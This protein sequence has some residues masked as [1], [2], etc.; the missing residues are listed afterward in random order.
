MTRL[1]TG[2]AV[3]VKQKTRPTSLC[4]SGATNRTSAG[5]ATASANAA[6]GSLRS[7]QAPSVPPGAPSTMVAVPSE[8][9]AEAPWKGSAAHAS[10]TIAAPSEQ[11]SEAGWHQVADEQ[12]KAT[13]WYNPATGESRWDRPLRAIKVMNTF[14]G[15]RQLGGA[16][17]PENWKPIFD[18]LRGRSYWI[19]SATG[20]SQWNK[21]MSVV[22]VLNA[23]S[24]PRCL[25]GDSASVVNGAS[26]VS[27]TAPTR[28]EAPAFLPAPDI[29]SVSRESS[30]AT[31]PHS[32]TETDLILDSEWEEMLDGLNRTYFV[33]RATGQSRWQK[34]M[35]AMR[36][37]GMFM[38]GRGD[39]N[40]WRQQSVYPKLG[41]THVNSATG[42]RVWKRPPGFDKETSA[43][44]PLADVAVWHEMLSKVET[45]GSELQ[46]L[47]ADMKD[48][49]VNGA[50]W[51]ERIDTKSGRT[52]FVNPATGERVWK[53][54]PSSDENDARTGRGIG[55]TPSRRAHE[56]RASQLSGREAG[57]MASPRRA[58]IEQQASTRSPRHSEDD[59]YK[60]HGM[61]DAINVLTQKLDASERATRQALSQQSTLLAQ[62][63]AN[64]AQQ[65]Q[66]FGATESGFQVSSDWAPGLLATLPPSGQDEYSEVAV[67]QDTYEWLSG[68]C[69]ERYAKDLAVQKVKHLEDVLGLSEQQLQ[70]S[71]SIQSVRTEPPLARFVLM[72]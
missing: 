11:A 10:A 43:G 45:V 64:P 39:G 53:Q 72:L 57:G 8:Q 16:A 66:R 33:N 55:A 46:Q 18:E 44:P 71:N 30:Q 36:A 41:K 1:T 51:Q 3:R 21:P 61:E 50:T 35:A 19:N 2:M 24:G 38:R 54:P 65:V 63:T 13:F 27:A 17:A 40:T 67:A 6:V 56:A 12:T 22:K 28:V 9:P 31:S 69:L 23:F 14:T 68:F 59:M 20:E 42:E 52:Y 62:V 5:P 37:T 25:G 60:M 47:R 48:G 49:A 70:V 7:Q 58:R 4:V 32:T 26:V 15:G 29:L 34:P